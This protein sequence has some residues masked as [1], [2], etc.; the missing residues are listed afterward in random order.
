MPADGFYEWQQRGKSKQPFGITVKDEN[1]FSFA[2]LY[3]IW[4]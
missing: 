1:I 4:T 2:G 3:D